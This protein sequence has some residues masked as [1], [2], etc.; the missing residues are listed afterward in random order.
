MDKCMTDNNKISYVNCCFSVAVST[1][2]CISLH[3]AFILKAENNFFV[4][5]LM[6]LNKIP[7]IRLVTL[8]DITLFLQK[9][10]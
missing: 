6:K 2:R 5:F 10:G 1:E 4:N 8:V 3:M 9:H 7:S